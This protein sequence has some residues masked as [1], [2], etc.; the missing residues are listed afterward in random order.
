MKDDTQ[1]PWCQQDPLDPTI[2]DC[3]EDRFI[4]NNATVKLGNFAGSVRLLKT[5][6]TTRRLFVV[7]RGDPSV[8]YLDVDITP[9]S[10]NQ[11]TRGILDCRAADAHPWTED[12]PPP[13]TA[14]H[15]LQLFNCRKGDP[16]K[17]GGTTAQNDMGDIS[18]TA[19]FP[20]CP[21][22]TD[23]LGD[24]QIPTEP[25]G[26]K[27]DVAPDRSYERLLVS[28]L[29]TGQVSFVDASIPALVSTS[30][31]FFAPTS[32]G[33]RGA[34]MLAPQH[35]GVAGST[36]YM[37]SNQTPILATFHIADVKEIVPAGSFSLQSTFVNN[38][39][40]RDIIFDVDGNRAFITSNS[41]PSVL[42]L[43]THTV[44]T[45]NGGQPANVVTSAVDVCQTPSHMASLRVMVEGAPG[46][47]PRVKT[48]LVVVCFL[49]GQLMIVD[50]D[51]PGVDAT[52]YSGFGGPDDLAFT[53]PRQLDGTV[54]PE[55]DVPWEHAWVTNY[56]ESTISIVDLAPGS[57][58][59]NRVIARL[60]LPQ[61][62]PQGGSGATGHK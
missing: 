6:D 10:V 30:E 9:T 53:R 37:T 23:D 34:F 52:I 4:I 45:L 59:E 25:F 39:D 56:T 35:P 26:I 58:N 17:G 42:T 54:V 36:W 20:F 3:D 60:G 7:V 24:L 27:L 40:M 2:V 33:L 61:D 15:L 21:A 8:T 46:T 32:S 12:S 11:Q 41:P 50:P 55:V 51:R 29:S 16:V 19:G 1:F 14:D 62:G 57:T 28:H 5:G 47:P 48:K 38:T 43:D 31:Q 18:E 49:S 22:G 44:G 13:C